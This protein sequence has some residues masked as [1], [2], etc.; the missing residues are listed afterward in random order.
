M[1][2]SHFLV[3]GFGV[4]CMA[5][6][7]PSSSAAASVRPADLPACLPALQ[8]YVPLFLTKEDLDVA[9]SGAYRQRNAAQI[10][11]VKDKV[12][13][14]AQRMLLVCLLYPLVCSPCVAHVQVAVK[15][16]FVCNTKPAMR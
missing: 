1:V 14:A 11:A 9:V 3:R 13:G 7:S 6:L 12:R 4:V 2:G 10:S 8:Q 16:A 5:Q 15:E